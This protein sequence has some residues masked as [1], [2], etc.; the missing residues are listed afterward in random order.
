LDRRVEDVEHDLAFEGVRVGRVEGI[1]ELVRGGDYLRA[2]SDMTNIERA[3]INVGSQKPQIATHDEH[4]LDHEPEHCA[5]GDE[6]LH[7]DV[8][9]Y[10]GG[11]RH[12]TD[13]EACVRG[14][15]KRISEDPTATA[16]NSAR[17][18]EPR[19]SRTHR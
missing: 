2:V 14:A 17:M 10:D 19:C 13:D 6:P 3:D 7:G 5:G 16:R 9:C 18:R 12:G 11:S 4:T 1:F 15:A 8:D